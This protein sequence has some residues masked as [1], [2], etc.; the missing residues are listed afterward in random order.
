MQEPMNQRFNIALMVIAGLVSGCEDASSNPENIP[1]TDLVPSNVSAE[2]GDGILQESELCDD[3]NRRS[4]D[5]CQDTCQRIEAGF[6]CYSAGQPCVD[7][8]LYLDRSGC[9]KVYEY[10]QNGDGATEAYAVI[11]FSKGN[12]WGRYLIFVR[13]DLR[14]DRQ[15]ARHS[16]GDLS[17]V[18][19]YDRN[20]SM[21]SR[22]DYTYNESLELERIS[23][24]D[25]GDGYYDRWEHYV[26]NDAG[27]LVSQMNDYHGDDVCDVAE[28]LTYENG[29]IVR[30]DY[31]YGCD[32][33]IDAEG[34]VTY[35][36]QSEALY[37]FL[38]RWDRLSDT[39]LLYEYADNGE[40]VGY[41]YRTIG[42]EHSEESIAVL[43]DSRGRVVERY[44]DLNGDG[45][46]DRVWHASE[47]DANRRVTQWSVV[48]RQGHV[49]FTESIW[50]LQ[51]GELERKERHDAEGNLSQQVV[52]TFDDLGNVIEELYDYSGNGY[53]DLVWSFE[54][55][56]EGQLIQ[57]TKD[58][59]HNPGPE[60]V[61]EVQI[62]YLTWD[63]RG[64]PLT[65]EIDQ[66][67]D[68]WIDQSVTL[69]WD[70]E[71]RLLEMAQTGSGDDVPDYS[72]ATAVDIE[73]KV[74][75]R[76]VDYYA[77]G[78]WDFWE[79]FDYSD[80]VVSTYRSDTNGDGI[81]DYGYDQ[82][83]DEEGR[84]DLYLSD[85]NGDG[86]ADF[87]IEGV[88]ECQSLDD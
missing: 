18:V 64:K 43:T 69:R 17:H 67:N 19:T 36:E 24:D 54:Y 20:G 16:N 59:T 12:Q 3:G 42:R 70:S 56:A 39:V 80:D 77:D 68:G 9:H 44:Q 38:T 52:R 47:W 78:D 29:R 25:N 6:Y 81:I 65:G 23:R 5:G 84:L 72:E 8:S 22:E 74:S 71:G 7:F 82:Y 41:N 13:D 48:S 57:E 62:S 66:G 28:H 49:M 26:W 14:L 55:N 4:G 63:E 40:L 32:F 61:P 27:E 46:A 1:S 88:T 60:G 21:A 86:Y 50:Y 83:L 45:Q 35:R 75:V 37:G 11:E 73:G 79:F 58:Y 85:H 51:N 31:D 10:D 2:C 33:N 34:E 76:E 30:D 87:R 53:A 15:F